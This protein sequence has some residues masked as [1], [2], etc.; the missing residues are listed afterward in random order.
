MLH[1]TGTFVYSAISIKV[2]LFK[3]QQ[4]CNPMERYIHDHVIEIKPAR[5][6]EVK[7]VVMLQMRHR[8]VGKLLTALQHLLLMSIGMKKMSWRTT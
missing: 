2:S 7:V 3:H 8:A 4:Y 1:V 6:Q 5:L